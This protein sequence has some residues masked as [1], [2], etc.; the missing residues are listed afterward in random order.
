ML[1]RRPSEIVRDIYEVKGKLET[2]EQMLNIR[3]M[4]SEIMTEQAGREPEQWVVRLE[5][6]VTEAQNT[7]EKLRGLKASLD[8]LERELED[9]LWVLG[10]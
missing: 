1:Y 5:E 4:L 7:L 10:A 9:A 6:A 3:N 8:T 2:M